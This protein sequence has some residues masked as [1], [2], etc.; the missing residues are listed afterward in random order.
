[1]LRWSVVSGL[2]LAAIFSWTAWRTGML[3][4]SGALAATALGTGAVAAGWPW[5]WLLVA[6][7]V[8]SSGLSAISGARKAKRSESVLAK[9]GKRDATQVLVNGAIFVIAALV[10]AATQS[11]VWTAAAIGSLAAAS[12]DT[13]GTELGMLSNG[14]PWSL[15]ERRRVSAGTS[16]AVSWI[17]IVA[18]LSGALF[19]AVIAALLG[20]S[21]RVV[22]AAAVAGVFGASLDTLL[23]AFV[24]AQ[25]SCSRCGA[26]TERR[27]HSCGVITNLVRG[28]A[29]VNNDTV[30]FIC[31]GMGA[32]AAVLLIS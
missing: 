29:W 11:D 28:P 17:G 15:L 10:A 23:G 18:T 9:G 26:K 8:S 32:V 13:W 4:R 31:S 12:A 6:F 27:V 20:W 2:A 25:W 3:A 7:F 24:Q 5:A 22:V 30:N 14:D 21:T 1:M 16:G 19:V